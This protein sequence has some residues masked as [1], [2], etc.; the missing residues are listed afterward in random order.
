VARTLAE[1][2]RARDAKEAANLAWAQLRAIQ[3]ESWVRF[4][5][6]VR[7]HIRAHG[8]GQAPDGR[9]VLDVMAAAGE[10]Y[11]ARVAA[12]QRIYLR[13]AR[14]ANRAHGLHRA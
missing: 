8:A 13:V 5:R 1:R 14:E 10:Q 2:R 9:D 7:E 12:E 6:V 11:I 3:E 4:D